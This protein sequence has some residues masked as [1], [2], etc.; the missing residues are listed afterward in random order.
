MASVR[1]QYMKYL[2]ARLQ[3]HALYVENRYKYPRSRPVW[4]APDCRGYQDERERL[5]R[6]LAWRKIRRHQLTT[7]SWDGEPFWTF[8]QAER[9][10]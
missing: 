5:L 9:K 7:L 4:L 10:F 3:G 8:W 1:R 2:V 6:K